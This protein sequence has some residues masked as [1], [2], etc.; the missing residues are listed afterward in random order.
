MHN[1]CTYTTTH[2]FPWGIF[3]TN[4]SKR[5]FNLYEVTDKFCDN[6]EA[7][8]HAREIGKC[9]RATPDVTREKFIEEHSNS[10]YPRTACME[11]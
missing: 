7:Q 11:F 6:N 1:V 2:A 8:N 9:E 4:L 3:P 10:M 5:F